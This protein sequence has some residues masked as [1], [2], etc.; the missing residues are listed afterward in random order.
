MMSDAFK[1]LSSFPSPLAAPCVV[2][3]LRRGRP[4]PEDLPSPAACQARQGRLLEQSCPPL[5]RLVL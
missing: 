5:L 2:N 1:P 4:H 3:T